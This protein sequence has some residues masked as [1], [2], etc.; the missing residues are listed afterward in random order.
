MAEEEN[1]NVVSTEDELLHVCQMIGQ[2]LDLA[3]ETEGQAEDKDVGFRKL[4]HAVKMGADADL[5]EQANRLN[6]LH[7]M[8]GWQAEMVQREHEASELMQQLAAKNQ[9]SAGASS[10]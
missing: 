10:L 1:E 5:D 6:N 3:T 7:M 9:V 8:G 2:G 4:T